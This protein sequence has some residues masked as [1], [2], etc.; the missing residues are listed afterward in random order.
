M[1][2][3]VPSPLLR[4]ALLADAATSGACGA[5][6]LLGAGFLEGLLGL[7][8][9]LLRTSGAFLIG[10]AGLVAVL[11]TRPT[12]PNVLVWAVIL[13]NAV[14][15]ADSVLL[16]VSGWV[17]P[18]RAGTAFVILQALAVAMY[19]ELQWMGLRRSTVRTA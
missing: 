4:Q 15:A 19:A 17:E 7:P 9:P 18:S 13:G 3:L 11:G 8:G 6:L 14:W 16:L 2:V 10:Y 12:L 1:S 5:L